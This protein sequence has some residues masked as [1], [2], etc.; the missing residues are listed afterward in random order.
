MDLACEPPKPVSP[1]RARIFMRQSL[2]PLL[3]CFGMLGGCSLADVGLSAI[4]LA[5]GDDTDDNL[6]EAGAKDFVPCNLGKE[7]DYLWQQARAWLD[8]KARF[9]AAQRNEDTLVAFSPEPDQN[10]TDHQYRITRIS[11]E[12]GTAT[13]KVEAFCSDMEACEDS[14]VNQVYE[15]N[16]FLRNHKRAL[17]EGLVEVESYAEPELPQ[18]GSDTEPDDADATLSEISIGKE[19]HRGRHHSQ[20]EEALVGAGCLKRSKMA[21]LKSDPDE[22]LYEVD[23]LTGIR[24][25]VFRCTQD[26]CSVL[27]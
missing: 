9:E 18:R 20:A 22:D 16:E 8:E 26:G 7:C 15:I 4:D 12:G 24:K 6:I 27:E 23:C 21:L 1:F 25:I 3:L 13:L 11:H 5:L 10:R 2:F 17:N 19:Y 14:A